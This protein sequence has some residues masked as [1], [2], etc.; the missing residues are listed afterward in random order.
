MSTLKD[1]FIGPEPTLN[2]SHRYVPLCA[3]NCIN[4]KYVEVLYEQLFTFIFFFYIGDIQFNHKYIFEY[5][6][7]FQ[8]T[9]RH[10][11]CS[12]A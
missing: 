11:K 7:N 8:K 9:V 1:Y 2:L 10:T 6:Y 5:K 3:F 12:I 4:F